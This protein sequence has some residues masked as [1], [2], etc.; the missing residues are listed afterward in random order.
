M[1]SKYGISRAYQDLGKID[2]KHESG[3][4]TKKQH[5][6]QSKKVLRRL[7]RNKK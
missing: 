7:M 5:D 2:K 4:I 1:K 6:N 3:K